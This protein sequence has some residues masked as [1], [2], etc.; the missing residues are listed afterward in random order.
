VG[1]DLRALLQPQP[2]IDLESLGSAGGWRV[3]CGAASVAVVDGVLKVER[4]GDDALDVLRAAA[5][6]C[7]AHADGGPATGPAAAAVQDLGPVLDVVR[8]LDPAASWA[9]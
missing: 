6:A 8:R 5:Q 3:R 7:W 1:R 2:E 9:R 4:P